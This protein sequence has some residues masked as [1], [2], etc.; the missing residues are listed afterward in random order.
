MNTDDKKQVVITIIDN[1]LFIQLQ[2]ALLLTR[3]FVNKE[4]YLQESCVNAPLHRIYSFDCPEAIMQRCFPDRVLVIFKHC[5][6]EKPL[7]DI[8]SMINAEIAKNNNTPLLDE[9]RFLAAIEREDVTMQQ[10]A[11]KGFDIGGVFYY[12][13][14]HYIFE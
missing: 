4:V 6:K 10:E 7:A 13:S 14:R 11:Y 1:N 12:V 5:G 3:A 2:S 8:L 9:G